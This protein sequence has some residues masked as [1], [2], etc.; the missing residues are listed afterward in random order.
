[1]EEELDA[2]LGK[3]RKKE[4]IEKLQALIKYLLNSEDKKI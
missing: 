2:V 3:K 1:M 4:I